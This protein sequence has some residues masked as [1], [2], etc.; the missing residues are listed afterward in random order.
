MKLR[1]KEVER[2]SEVHTESKE[3]CDIHSASLTP[4]I[5]LMLP[6]NTAAKYI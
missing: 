6:K 5:S 2:L 3:E 1:A 4:L